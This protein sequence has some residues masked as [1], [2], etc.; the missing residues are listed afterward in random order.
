VHRAG[1]RARPLSSPSMRGAALVIICLIAAGCGA[2]SDRPAA[3]TE[4]TPERQAAPRTEPEIRVAELGDGR[5][6][7][8]RADLVVVPRGT[9]G[10]EQLAREHPDAHFLLIGSSYERARAPNV[11]GVLFRED[12]AAYLAGVVAGLVVSGEGALDASVAWVGG[13]RIAIADAFERGVQ[14]I[15]PAVRVTRTWS[16]TRPA[17]CKEAALDEVARGASVL[18]TGTGGCADGV[19]AAAREQNVVGLSLGDFER[20]EIAVDQFVRDAR[21]GLFHGQENVVFGTASGA[22]GVGTLDARVPADAVAEARAVEQEVAAGLR[23]P[24]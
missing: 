3:T 20:P 1:L 2:G 4:P 15:D 18:L 10:V 24:G 13:R 9:R 5:A 6:S 19:L 11:A 17:L 22:V 8:D 21:H 16:E 12:E 23:S 14:G 7:L